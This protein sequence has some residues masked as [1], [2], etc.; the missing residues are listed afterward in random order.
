VADGSSVGRAVADPLRPARVFA[1]FFA[2]GAVVFLLVAAGAAV[3]ATRAEPTVVVRADAAALELPDAGGAPELRL[4]GARADDAP[5]PDDAS[6]T[7]TTTGRAR[8]SDSISTDVLKVHGRSLRL[9]AVVRSGWAPGDTVSC[10]GVDRLVATRGGGPLP[11]LGLAGLCL[12]GAV[13]SAVLWLVGRS[14]RRARAR[15]AGRPS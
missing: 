7:L 12:A 15:P 14:S 11:R 9:V 1:P 3:S 10:T 8:A 5:V 6:C 2:V 4:W 13:L